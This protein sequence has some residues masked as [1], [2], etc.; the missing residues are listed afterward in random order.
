MKRKSTK[1]PKNWSIIKLGDFVESEKGK[2][3]KNLQ[4][5]PDQKHIYPYIDIEAFEKGGVR[6]WSDGVNCRQCYASDLLM[7]W[8]G[9]RSGLVGRGQDGVLG[10]TLVR[11]NFRGINND[12]T[13]HFLKSKY[14]QINTKAK[15]SGTPHVDQYILWNYELPVP[16]QEEQK[17]I[18]AK[19]EELFSELDNGV[20][21][22]KAAREKLKT[23]R[24][25]VLKQAF[26]GKLTEQWREDSEK[27]LLPSYPATAEINAS[28]LYKLPSL[29][30][31]WHYVRLSSVGELDRGKS[32][33][34]P[35]NDPSLFGGQYP[36]LQT[37]EVKKADRLI[38][39]YTNTYNEKG[40]QQSKLWPKGTLCITIAANIAET[41][42]L[43]FD[44]CFPDSVVGFTA[45]RYYVLPEY[46]EF[47]FK[48]KQQEIQAFAPATAQKNINLTT[49]KNLVLPICSID[50]QR[51]IIN[52]LEA[53]L[54]AINQNE[55][56]IKKNVARV[57][58]LKQS[59]LKKAF[60]GE[61]VEQDPND[62]PASVLLER[63]RAE[64]NPNKTEK[65]RK[66]IA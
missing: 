41:S 59:V 17:R 35:R 40:L 44:A 21:S 19:I 54:E 33:H 18:V 23:Y 50:E 29:P 5:H 66:E 42:F 26:E 24:Q 36:F 9:S 2:K 14:L 16:P 38:K 56:E 1:Y 61:L 34:R 65:S 39:T 57:K 63:M 62:E 53:N 58:T 8:D 13:Y 52:T 37:S 49:L 3:P 55:F 4:T 15:G 11:I 28:E 30:N 60:S 7:V 22:L 25:A 6:S 64:E 51:K 48:A 43:D 20:E 10:S 31:E 45:N 12:Y 46:V 27:L 47:F 32:K